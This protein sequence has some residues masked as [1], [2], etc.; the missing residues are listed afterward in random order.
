MTGKWLLMTDFR[1]G[2]H[3]EDTK[4]KKG[5]PSKPACKTLDPKC[6]QSATGTPTD[7]QSGIHVGKKER[8]AAL[9]MALS[10]WLQG[11]RLSCVQ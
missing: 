11:R 3:K 10:P 6:F 1:G 7:L 2:R 9:T 5:S 4:G 8:P